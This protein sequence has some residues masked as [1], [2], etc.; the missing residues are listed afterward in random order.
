M[1]KFYEKMKDDLELKGLSERTQKLYLGEMRRFVKHFYKSPDN[2]GEEEIK[3]YLLYLLREKKCSTSSVNLAYSAIKFFYTETLG[4]KWDLKKIC[5]TK[6]PKKLPVVMDIEEINALLNVTKNIK[7]R[8]I[9]TVIYSAGLRVSEA[10]KLHVND[11]DSK[12]M[13]IRIRSAKGAKDRYT[14]L[15]NAALALLQKYWKTYQPKDWLFPGQK[16]GRQITT[17]TIQ[18]VFETNKE[19]AKITKPVTVHS[20]RHSFATHLLENGTDLHHVQ[21]LLGHK[22]SSTTT[23]YLHVKRKDLINIISP[24]DIYNKINP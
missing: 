17:R 1:G 2:L 11:I 22:S 23:I 7:H 15:S 6:Q 24:L 3:E 10:S 4:Q 20:L 8:T 14:I 18:S 12:R 19:K 16:P 9:F 21:L 5:R 13:Q